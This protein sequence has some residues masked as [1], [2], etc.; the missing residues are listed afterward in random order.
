M[1]EVQVR[2]VPDGTVVELRV[3]GHTGYAD[4]GEDIVCAGISALVVTALIGL[5]RVAKHP[6]EGKAAAGT[7]YCKLKPGGTPETAMK[8]QAILETAVLGLR[9]IA[10]DYPD[11]IRVTEGG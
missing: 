8:A 7:M 10:K 2:R 5:K 4:H 9:D 11:F 1:T 6:H 3:S